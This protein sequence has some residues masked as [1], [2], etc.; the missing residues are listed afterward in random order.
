VINPA[1]DGIEHVNIY[2]KGATAVGRW[3]SNFTF[4]PFECEDGK[5]ASIEGY[6][7]WLSCKDDRLRSAYGFAAKKLGR[8]LRGADWQDSA[9]FKRKICAAIQAKIN[10]RPEVKAWLAKNTLP[11]L[12]YYVFNGMVKDETKRAHWILECLK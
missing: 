8:E 10:T 1:L 11:L 4:A 7:Y 6:W 5:F 2:S 12:H 9:E 3:L